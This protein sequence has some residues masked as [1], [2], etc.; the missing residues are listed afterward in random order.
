[1]NQKN[2]QIT[3]QD[4]AYLIETGE[5]NRQHDSVI[6]IEKG[7][8]GNIKN[9]LVIKD[10]E[11][12]K[13][14]NKKQKEGFRKKLE[15]E[16]E[17]EELKIFIAEHNGNYV[18]LFFDYNS[19]L[20]SELEDK[21]GK[22]NANLHIVRLVILANYLNKNNNLVTKQNNR[23]KRGTLNKIWDNG[24]KNN[25]KEINKTFN[26]LL[27]AN[28]IKL[29]G[30]FIM[31]NEDIIR[32]GTISKKEKAYTRVFTETIESIYNETPPR[33]R[34]QIANIIK[35]A[36]FINFKY[37]YL[38]INPCET[39]SNKIIPL[40]WTDIADIC[41]Y[42]SAK[43]LSRFKKGLAELE[44]A[45]EPLIVEFKIKNKSIIAVNPRIL[46]G[47][48]NVDDIKYL[49]SIFETYKNA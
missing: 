28:L 24:G 13:F 19:R 11:D 41:G 5:F 46:Y 31:I 3:I 4:L 42:D 39:D 21:L 6:I 33:K 44:V 2:K 26:I 7:S 37:N 8:T 20:F 1:M 15:K 27:E 49:F 38:C 43:Q 18:H 35:I 17:I 14:E 10:N 9:D 30:D 34:K 23:I 36:P 12:I 32:V 16:K 25:T 40:K 22:N 47:G 29:E 48:S 45:D